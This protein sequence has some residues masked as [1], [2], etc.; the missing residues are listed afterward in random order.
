MLYKQNTRCNSSC[1]WS[2]LANICF[3]ALNWCNFWKAV[4]RTL[5]WGLSIGPEKFICPGNCTKW[6]TTGNVPNWHRTNKSLTLPH[7]NKLC[8]ATMHQ[9]T[10]YCTP[11]HCAPSSSILHYNKLHITV[12]H[13]VVF[14][15][16]AKLLFIKSV[17]ISIND[18]NKDVCEG[19]CDPT[20]ENSCRSTVAKSVFASGNRFFEAEFS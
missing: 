5:L 17:Q 2:N 15:C 12:T 4:L 10:L 16:T 8:Y 20:S 1:I 7:C 6:H 14:H 13:W 11:S 18:H 9:N 3:I 19:E